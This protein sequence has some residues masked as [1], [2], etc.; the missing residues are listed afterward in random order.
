M[1]QTYWASV[2]RGQIRLAEGLALPEGASV[3]V[4]VLSDDENQFWQS[5]SESSLAG[6]WDNQ[7][8]EVYGQLLAE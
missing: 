3:L 4:T 5:A 2:E 8:D 6:I 7:E 1:L